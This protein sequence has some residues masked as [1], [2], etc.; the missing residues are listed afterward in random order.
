MLVLCFIS[1]EPRNMT[2]LSWFQKSISGSRTTTDFYPHHRGVF[3]NP[4]VY[5]VYS[6]QLRTRVQG[7][8]NGGGSIHAKRQPRTMFFNAPCQYSESAPAK[9]LQTPKESFGFFDETLRIQTAKKMGGS[10]NLN[11]GLFSLLLFSEVKSHK[12]HVL[13]SVPA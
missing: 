2:V 10:W 6:H 3:P 9:Y 5:Q 12:T 1:S 13:F 7:L 4:G 8:G 11:G